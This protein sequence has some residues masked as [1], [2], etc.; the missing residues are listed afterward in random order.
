MCYNKY[1][2]KILINQGFILKNKWKGCKVLK[3]AKGKNVKVNILYSI[4]VVVIV[5]G[6]VF[7]TYNAADNIV[8]SAS[9]NIPMS[10]STTLR[11]YST[12]MQ[13]DVNNTTDELT[14]AQ[15]PDT[16]K[17]QTNDDIKS[18]TVE[19]DDCVYVNEDGDVVYSIQKGDTLCEISDKFGYSVDEIAEY[20]RI[21]NVNLIYA[22]SSL[23]IPSR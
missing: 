6:V 16:T 13:S 1:S 22:D 20:N 2:I 12:T 11:E 5:L 7:L 19:N 21:R 15:T 10:V 9:D 3:Q 14:S 17:E 8:S 4:G 23:R 18:S